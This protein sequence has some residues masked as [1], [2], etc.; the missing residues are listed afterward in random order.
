MKKIIKDEAKK[1]HK[2]TKKFFEEF[3]TFANKGN[4]IDLAVGVVIGSAFTKI[5][6][7]LVS[8]LIMPLISIITGGTDVSDWKW[9]IDPNTRVFYV[10]G[11][12][13]VG[14]SYSVKMSLCARES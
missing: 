6:N 5:V 7:N 8:G 14:K 3:K 11:Q 12:R 10:V 1:A 13:G 9:V 2:K 4:A